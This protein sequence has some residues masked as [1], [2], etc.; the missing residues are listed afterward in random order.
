[1]GQHVRPL[2]DLVDLV[3]ERRQIDTV[4]GVARLLG[5]EGDEQHRVYAWQ[6]PGARG[7]YSGA[8]GLLDAAGFITDEGR[9]FLGLE[10][11]RPGSAGGV[12]ELRAAVDQGRE[13][14]ASVEDRLQEREHGRSHGAER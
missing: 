9:A 5:Y 2:S 1:M 7:S 6:K 13:L 3:M 4:R 11:G 8:V 14:G 12:D 10:R